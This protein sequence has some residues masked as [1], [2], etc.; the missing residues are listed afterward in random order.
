MQHATTRLLDLSNLKEN[1]LR[2]ILR[3]SLSSSSSQEFRALLAQSED[4]LLE[5]PHKSQPSEAN[6]MALP[7]QGP[8]TQQRAFAPKGQARR[9]RSLSQVRSLSCWSFGKTLA[10]EFKWFR[11]VLSIQISAKSGMEVAMR[12]RKITSTDV[13]LGGHRY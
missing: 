2:C 10:N 7:H 13:D 4:C 5:A 6:S 3:S 12:K 11:C 1:P 9:G 8:K